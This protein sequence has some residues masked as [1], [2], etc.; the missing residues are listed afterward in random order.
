MANP[1]GDGWNIKSLP[2]ASITKR[3][4]EKDVPAALENLEKLQG[5]LKVP[6]Y[7]KLIHA[8]GLDEWYF[9]EA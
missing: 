8:L 7:E 5:H 2:A 6:E 3:K 9:K 1:K 4:M